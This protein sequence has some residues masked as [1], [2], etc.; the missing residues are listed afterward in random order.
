MGV[1]ILPVVFPVPMARTESHWSSLHQ[2]PCQVGAGPSG[3]LT[4]ASV[5]RNEAQ[6]QVSE[7]Q[8]DPPCLGSLTTLLLP[9][10]LLD[11]RS[12]M[13]SIAPG[14][15]AVALHLGGGGLPGLLR[16]GQS[17]ISESC[18]FFSPLRSFLAP[19]PRG[20]HLIANIR[21]S[22]RFI[23]CTNVGR[24]PPGHKRDQIPIYEYLRGRV[25]MHPS[26]PAP[27]T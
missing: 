12:P 6:D 2:L 18:T 25:C 21:G 27:W 3:F 16:E 15:G 11:A 9:P 4:V 10:S 7:A 17:Y 22:R 20:L 14:N 19:F 26:H 13:D 5:E 23:N 1:S 24:F 8:R